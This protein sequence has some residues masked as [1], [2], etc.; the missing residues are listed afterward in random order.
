MIGHTE[1]GATAKK[2]LC[3][4]LFLPLSL[5]GGYSK[6][7]A[8]ASSLVS[9]LKSKC[10]SSAP[11][12]VV[13]SFSEKGF[14]VNISQNGT[15][16]AGV[17]PE[18]GLDE[19]VGLSY[20]THRGHFRVKW[21]GEPGTTNAGCLG[22]FNIAPEKPLWDFPLPPD[23]PDD[24]QL[25]SVEGRKNPRYRC[26]NSV[27]IHV[28]EGASFWGTA[29]DLSLGGCYVQIPIP[30]ELGKS[31]KVGIWFGQ[32]KAWADA[33]VTHTVP[34]LGVGLKFTQISES[35]LDQIRRFLETLSPLARKARRPVVQLRTKI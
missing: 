23:A 28:Q 9:K 5:T 17:K 8:G 10:G 15:Q 3:L 35:D 31:L 22:L 26:Q 34:G 13:T 32:S 24:Y 20:G 19:I 14:T 30:L 33:R 25:T 12:A 18:V 11:T 7:W 6:E 29:A 2:H 16:L 4:L 27:E 21:I 1:L